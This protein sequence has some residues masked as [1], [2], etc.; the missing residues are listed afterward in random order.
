MS[1]PSYSAFRPHPWH[2]I[3][4]GKN[5]P[6]FLNAF[7]EITPFDGVKYEIDKASG[8]LKVDRP[9]LSSA[10]PPAL[11]GFVPKTYCGDRVGR[12]SKAAR[13]GDGDPLD[14]VVFSERAIQRSEV[15]V[16]ARVIGGLRMVDRGE[17]DDKIIAVLENDPFWAEVK[18][19]S[20]LPAFLLNRLKHY[21]LTYKLAIGGSSTS[22]SAPN[23]VTIES[24]Y[25]RD[26]A[27]KV[28]LASLED[29]GSSVP[30]PGP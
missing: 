19:L 10:L 16:P 12:L 3:P 23:P 14:I 28:V 21:F 8:Y 13:A 20:G 2:G 5:P 1:I 25:G 17:A 11:Y 29:Y 4:A 30:K 22:D 15:I 24:I 18:D 27:F 26:E 6:E 7:I 9:Q